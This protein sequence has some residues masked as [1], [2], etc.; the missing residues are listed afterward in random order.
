[1]SQECTHY[2]VSPDPVGKWPN[3]D[4]GACTELNLS[5]SCYF[6]IILDSRLENLY[7]IIRKNKS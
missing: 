3:T 6:Y 4:V 2:S 7:E 1:M 5:Y